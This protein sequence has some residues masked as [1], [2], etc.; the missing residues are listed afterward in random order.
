MPESHFTILFAKS[1]REYLI[2]LLKLTLSPRWY[3]RKNGK[4][5]NC[6]RVSLYRKGDEIEWIFLNL[7]SIHFKGTLLYFICSFTFYWISILGEN[8]FL[9]YWNIFVK[10]QKKVINEPEITNTLE[11][12]QKMHSFIKKIKRSFCCISF[13][14]FPF[15]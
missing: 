7:I 11:I 14:Y 10:T 8:I 2:I 9:N 13:L 3:R 15:F 6:F 1:G 5:S 12:L 4:K